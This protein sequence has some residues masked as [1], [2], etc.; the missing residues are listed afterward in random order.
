M[1]LKNTLI[2]AALSIVPSFALATESKLF[3]SCFGDHH[4]SYLDLRAISGTE[5]LAQV[6]ISVTGDGEDPARFFQ[7]VEVSKNF[8]PLEVKAYSWAIRQAIKAEAKNEWYG[9][10]KVKAVSDTGSVMYINL[11]KFTGSLR[12]ALV[13]DGVVE[14][15]TCPVENVKD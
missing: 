14:E 4:G 15:L 10:I 13:I 8:Q 7:V 9:F 2:V 5:G 11:Q 1:S 3:A 6:V 12:H